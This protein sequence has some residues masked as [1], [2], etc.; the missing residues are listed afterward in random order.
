MK[1]ELLEEH[2]VMVDV[3][4]IDVRGRLQLPANIHFREEDKAVET[5][6]LMDSAGIRLSLVDS[7]ASEEVRRSLLDTFRGNGSKRKAVIEKIERTL[8]VPWVEI[9]IKGQ[10]FENSELTVREGKILLQGSQ[11]VNSNWY[12]VS[13]EIVRVYN[14]LIDELFKISPHQTWV[15]KGVP[16]LSNTRLSLDIEDIPWCLSTWNIEFKK[17]TSD[18]WIGG[19]SFEVVGDAVAEVDL[20]IAEADISHGELENIRHSITALR[21]SEA[22][23]PVPWEYLY[24]A[25][26]HLA[27]GNVRN[28]VID[29]DIAID[30]VVRWYLT[31]K[32]TLNW[33]HIRKVLGESSTGDLILVA[34]AMAKDGSEFATWGTLKE[35]HALRGTVLHKYQRRFGKAHLELV[36]KAKAAIISILRDLALV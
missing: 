20:Q 24:Y 4:T 16:R 2:L 17:I 6:V 28:A 26:R 34:R 33:R 10:I 5:I 3:E 12:R 36:E 15:R 32:M 13:Q 30:Y 7:G 1:G 23:L 27:E 19:F 35:L 9:V 22:R 29:L 21:D 31:A 8:I 11:L 25:S 18:E 14:A